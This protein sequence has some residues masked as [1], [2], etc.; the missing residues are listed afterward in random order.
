VRLAKV[1]GDEHMNSKL[2]AQVLTMAVA[3]LGLGA[4]A[5]AKK[6]EPVAPETPAAT[7]GE[8]GVAPEGTPGEEGEAPKSEEGKEGGEGGEASCGGGSCGSQGGK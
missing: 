3:A 2:R 5:C 4:S 6:S 1:E 8:E 7:S